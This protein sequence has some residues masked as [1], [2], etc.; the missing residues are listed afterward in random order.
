MR[1]R[2]G[3][4][5]A[6]EFRRKDS[7]NNENRAQDEENDALPQTGIFQ[8]QAWWFQPA[9]L[10]LFKSAGPGLQPERLKSA[11]LRV[12]GVLLIRPARTLPPTVSDHAQR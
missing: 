9:R 2:I 5:V 3:F 10:G 7:G 4:R 8:L 12:E 1:V 11:A 6:K